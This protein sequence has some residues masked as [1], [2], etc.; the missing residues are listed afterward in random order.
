MPSEILR[1]LSAA[2]RSGI[3]W[4]NLRF[5]PKLVS[6][7]TSWLFPVFNSRYTLPENWTFEGFTLHD[8]RTVY[9]T[10]QAMLFGW[11]YVRMQ[12]LGHAR[13]GL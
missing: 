13:L 12:E 8:Y 5:N 1:R 9:S 11:H 7:L 6:A 3:D 2:T 10:L 4:F